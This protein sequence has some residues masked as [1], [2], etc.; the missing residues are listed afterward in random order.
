MSS[1]KAWWQEKKWEAHQEVFKRH[2]FLAEQNREMRLDNLLYLNI[3][4][5]WNVDGSGYGYGPLEWR[6]TN[7]GR[8]IRRNICQAGLDTAASLIAANRTIPSYSTNGTFTQAR[9][10]MHKA[11]CVHAQMWQLKVFDFGIDAFY[12]GGSCGSGITHLYRDPRTNRPSKPV[13]VKPNSLFTDAAEG[14]DPRTVDWV[15]FVA[16][17]LLRG[18]YK[19]SR[20]DIDEA[21]GPDGNDYEDF[22]I[23][24]DNRADLVKVVESWHLPSYPGADDGRH[25]IA[26][27]N[28]TLVDEPWTR[29]RFPFAF[30][31]Y[32]KR[33]AGFFGQGLVERMLPAQ[34]RLCE[35]QRTV[36]KSQD[37][38]SLAVWL[39]EENSGVDDEDLTN[40]E[41]GIVRY[42]RNAPQLVAWEGTPQDLKAEIKE[43]VADAF[44]QEGLSPGMVGGEL[45]QKGLSSARAIRAGDDVSSRRQVIPTRWLEEYYLQFAQLIEDVNDDCAAVDPNYTV[46]GY[47]RAG[48]QQF[49]TTKRWKDLQFSE[50]EKPTLTVMSMSAMPTTPQGR[51]A[52]VEEYIAGGFMS[53]PMAISLMEFPDIE[54]WQTLETADLDLVEYQIDRVLDGYAELP[55]ADQDPALAIDLMTKA[56]LVAYRLGADVEILDNMDRYVAYA[57]QLLEEAEAAGAAEGGAPADALAPPP[58]AVPPE[59]AVPMAA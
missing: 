46:N 16:R 27:S 49:S 58:G 5:N 24:Q 28:C 3:A 54:A 38:T 25:V 6:M 53:K 32:A 15:H 4:A 22:F 57:E 29:E 11:R 39:V 30:Y 17:S 36:D 34:I 12:D 48:R 59:A 55:I 1:F 2:Q 19:S 21:A 35:L 37:L 44:E 20:F 56:K 47:Y 26:I 45:V 52:A 9:R 31:H 33:R 50:D 14:R 10:A 7:N 18:T 8:K 42:Q 13:R 23:R 40:A 51:M 41:G 43:I